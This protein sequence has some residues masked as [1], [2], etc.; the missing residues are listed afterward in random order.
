MDTMSEQQ[1]PL[2]ELVRALLEQTEAGRVEWRGSDDPDTYLFRAPSG[3]VILTSD[4]DGR[5]PFEF[6]VLNDLGET[7]EYYDSR[8]HVVG[9]G[10]LEPIIAALFSAIRRRRK[11]SATTIDNLLRDLQAQ[12][13]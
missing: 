9:E 13:V 5:P 4:T 8:P 1:H 3:T 6:Q 2:Q 12:A 11:P 7:V 10:A